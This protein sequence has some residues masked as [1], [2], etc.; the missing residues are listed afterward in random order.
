MVVGANTSSAFAAMHQK[1]A[2]IDERIVLTGACNWTYTAFRKSEED[3][4]VI[5][6]IAVAKAFL[7]DFADLMKRYDTA[8]SPADYSYSDNSAAVNFVCE[9]ADTQ[10]GEVVCV[11]GNHPA[12]GHWDPQR[13]VRLDTAR[14]LF[15]RWSG[16][17]DL[18]AGTQIEYKYIRLKSD[19]S[20]IWEL[21]SNRILN[22]SSNGRNETRI[23]NFRK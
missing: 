16:F 11:V 12:L 6:D 17:V 15:P 22:T 21:G 4:L 8:Y 14:S 7:N 23:E 20:V 19:G 18:S 3:V 9:E 10:W 13:A 5:R 2:V 1:Y